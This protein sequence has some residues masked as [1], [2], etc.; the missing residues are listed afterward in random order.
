MTAIVDGKQRK[1]SVQ[2]CLSEGGTES[3]RGDSGMRSGQAKS[4]VLSGGEVRFTCME[5]NKGGNAQFY[6]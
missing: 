5:G 3:H 6:S 1:D 2:L 4:S